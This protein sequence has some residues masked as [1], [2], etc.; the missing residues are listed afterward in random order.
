MNATEPTPG[1]T[2]GSEL[3]RDRL[4]RRIRRTTVA[5]AA[6]RERLGAHRRGLDMAPVH[7]QQAIAD[8]EARLEEMNARL[9]DLAPD[10]G[11]IAIQGPE[12]P[13]SGQS[14]AQQSL[15]PSWGGTQAGPRN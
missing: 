11:S 6:L 14:G 13:R 7:L 1:R 3:E 15:R 4:T 10:R 8:F 5:I 2:L 12:P 9:V